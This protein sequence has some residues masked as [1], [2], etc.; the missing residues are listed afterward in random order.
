MS[1][2]REAALSSQVRLIL[3]A[4]SLLSP[5]T[6]HLLTSASRLLS[7]LTPQAALAVLTIQRPSLPSGHH[8]VVQTH[9]LKWMLGEVAFMERGRK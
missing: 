6:Q 3:H 1:R 2:T 9:D 4:H 5:E 7:S 8:S